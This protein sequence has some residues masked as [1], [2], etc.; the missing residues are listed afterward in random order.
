MTAPSMR[1][2]TLQEMALVVSRSPSPETVVQN[3]SSNDPACLWAHH[4]A[5]G[6]VSS[7]RTLAPVPR[8]LFASSTEAE[9]GSP[10]ALWRPCWVGPAGVLAS[11]KARSG[12]PAGRRTAQ[13]A[14]SATAMAP[15]W[16]HH[17]SAC[18]CGW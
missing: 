7:L 17:R 9:A 12:S 3:V 8:A 11:T 15:A 4:N 18:R 13:A 14:A 1:A 5:N 2:A 10:S 16:R 6:T